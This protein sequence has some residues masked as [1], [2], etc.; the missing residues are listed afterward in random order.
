MDRSST[1]FVPWPIDD[2]NGIKQKIIERS[3]MYID[4]LLA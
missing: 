3:E 1:S 4:M 2:S